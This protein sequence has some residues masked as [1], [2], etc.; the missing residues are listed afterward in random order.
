[1]SILK[2][3]V[4][5]KKSENRPY[6]FL[7]WAIATTTLGAMLEPFNINDRVSPSQGILDFDPSDP[8]ARVDDLQNVDPL[9]DF[10]ALS[11]GETMPI[12]GGDLMPRVYIKTGNF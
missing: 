6:R 2:R 9:D 3:T 11:F 5:Y 7:G 4:L 12:H 8:I 10:R 1:M